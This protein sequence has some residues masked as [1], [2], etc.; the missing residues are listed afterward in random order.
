MRLL[1]TLMLKLIRTYSKVLIT[2]MRGDYAADYA[3]RF[4]S[5]I[6]R[7]PHRAAL[8]REYLVVITLI[9]LFPTAEEKRANKW[10]NISVF[11]G[12]NPLPTLTDVISN[13]HRTSGTSV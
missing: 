1:I 3:F 11:C 7:N 13:H 5:V 8:L 6:S 4:K 12:F 10:L 2:L 9:T